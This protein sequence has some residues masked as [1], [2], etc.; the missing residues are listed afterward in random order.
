M[1]P[2]LIPCDKCKAMVPEKNFC[3]R[4]GQSLIQTVN[5]EDALGEFLDLRNFYLSSLS[6]QDQFQKVMLARMQ[7]L[8]IPNDGTVPRI[9]EIRVTRE[10][11]VFFAPSEY[12]DL[13]ALPLGTYTGERLFKG[14]GWATAV[15][16]RRSRNFCLFVYLNSQSITVTFQLPDW[17]HMAP[18][19][20]KDEHGKLKFNP[21][22]DKKDFQKTLEQLNIRSADF[23]F[24]G[25]QVQLKLRIANPVRF[26]D[27]LGTYMIDR[28]FPETERRQV[29][30]DNHGEEDARRNVEYRGILGFGRR[31]WKRCGEA[32]YGKET[33][34]STLVN[35]EFTLAELY[36]RIRVE[37]A[38]AVQQAVRNLQATDLLE[39]K[40]ETRRAVR[41][42]IKRF[43]GDTLDAYGM[44]VVEVPAFEFLCPDLFGQQRAQGEIELRKKWLEDQKKR[45]DLNRQTTILAKEEERFD[46]LLQFEDLK[47]KIAQAGE[48]GELRDENRAAAQVRQLDMDATKQD[49]TRKQLAENERLAITIGKEKA[50]AE[51]E[52]TAAKRARELA[53]YQKY[54]QITGGHEQQKSDKDQADFLAVLETVAKLPPNLQA[55]ALTAYQARLAATRP[56]LAAMLAA[57]QQSASQEQERARERE[58]AEK[59][60]KELSAAHTEGTKQAAQLLAA[61][62]QQAGNVMI[63]N[64]TGKPPL[65]QPPRTLP[66]NDPDRTEGGAQ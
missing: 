25:A 64:A 19:I 21:D 9:K 7:F 13:T 48:L 60:A 30:E 53:E 15:Q 44:E 6:M 10:S 41:D 46:N 55:A 65:P 35:R 40:D 59:H 39:N 12:S 8:S 20:S 42:D 17:S 22:T 1:P 29:N 58:T 16:D 4:C 66:N 61:I 34:R 28:A 26:L 23:F 63:A 50:L 45:M 43:M 38:Q 62:V 33:A 57:S 54:L 18:V 27:T 3:V 11:H 36:E 2:K 5:K 32:L 56:E 49:H 24:G 52:V 14:A 47:T 37:F 31:V 51:E